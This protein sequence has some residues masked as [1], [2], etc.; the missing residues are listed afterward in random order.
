MTAVEAEAAT[1]VGGIC[2]WVII[3]EGWG[4]RREGRE[5]GVQLRERGLRGDAQVSR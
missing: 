1:A 3:I 2:S 4:M 5:R